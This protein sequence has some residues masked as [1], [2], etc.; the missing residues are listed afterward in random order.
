MITRILMELY[1]DY[2]EGNLDSLK[3]FSN[4]TFKND[5]TSKLFF[6]CTLIMFSRVCGFKARYSVS[7]EYL[8]SIVLSVKKKVGNITLLEFYLD[9]INDKKNIN[10][11]F[12]DIFDDENLNDYADNILRYLDQFKH[13]DFIKE[14]EEYKDKLDKY[15]E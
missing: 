12:K 14:M 4:I 2:L 10:K 6:G 9:R 11:Y 15:K 8:Y 1:D 3:D 7:K 13:Q 5:G